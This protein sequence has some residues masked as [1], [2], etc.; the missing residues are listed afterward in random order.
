MQTTRCG[1]HSKARA[2]THL[3]RTDIR[4]GEVTVSLPRVAF[5]LLFGKI[6]Q[7]Y[8]IRAIDLLGDDGNLFFDGEVQGIKEFELGFALTSSN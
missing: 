2:S 6:A 8:A 4:T 7:L 1:Q 5:Y 3:Q